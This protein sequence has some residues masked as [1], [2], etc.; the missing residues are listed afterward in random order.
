MKQSVNVSGSSSVRVE[1]DVI[2]VTTGVTIGSTTGSHI[3]WLGPNTTQSSSDT[4]Q[5]RVHIPGASSGSGNFQINVVDIA[6]GS[7]DTDSSTH[8]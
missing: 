2:D 4:W 6:K 3:S 7:P 1:I 8:G 5:I